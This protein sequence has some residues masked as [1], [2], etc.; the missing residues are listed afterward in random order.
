LFSAI[1]LWRWR[2]KVARKDRR[3]ASRQCIVCGYDL[4]ANTSGVCPEC[5]SNVLT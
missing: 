2:R 1:G 3:L 5:G 4:T